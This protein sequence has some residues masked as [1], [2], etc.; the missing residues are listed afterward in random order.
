MPSVIKYVSKLVCSLVFGRNV[1]TCAPGTYPEACLP[2]LF[3]ICL[4]RAK[5]RWRSFSTGGSEVENE[6]RYDAKTSGYFG[7]LCISLFI[8]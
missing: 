5:E 7:Q 8:T 4:A 3:D 2:E 1:L 6:G